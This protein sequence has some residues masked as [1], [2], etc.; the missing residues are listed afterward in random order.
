MTLRKNAVLLVLPL[1]AFALLAACASGSGGEEISK[2][3]AIELARQHI[4][5]DP[6][7]IEAVKKTSEDG[8]PIWEVTFF[9]KGVTATNPGHVEV[10]QLDRKTGEMVSVAMS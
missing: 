2:E 6:E 8:R 9:A 5:M 1:I 7:R 10:I 3:R 4:Q